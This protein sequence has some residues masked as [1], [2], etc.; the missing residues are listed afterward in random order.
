MS[1]GFAYL[2]LIKKLI[3][4]HCILLQRDLCSVGPKI[5]PM[6]RKGGENEIK[7]AQG[8]KTDLLE[9][10]AYTQV[11]DC[12]NGQNFNKPTELSEIYTQYFYCY[13]IIVTDSFTWI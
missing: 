2:L 4:L 11:I 7:G 5:F 6:E 10:E 3:P 13:K 9:W 8:L 12:I 1:H